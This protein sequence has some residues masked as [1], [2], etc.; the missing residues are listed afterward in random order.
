MPSRS[1][2][3]DEL[4]PPTP[5]RVARR[6][7]ALA[8]VGARSLLEQQD[9]K[10]PDVEMTRVRVVEWVR[11]AGVEDE[12]EPGERMLLARG[13]GQVPRQEGVN[14]TWRLEGLVVLAWALGRFDLPPHDEMVD[15]GNL[16]P[17]LSILNVE[18]AKELLDAATLRPPEEIRQGCARAFAI[19]WRLRQFTM[20]D[21]SPI[22]FAEFARSAW[23]GPLDITGIRLV[24]KDLAVG[25][26]SISKAR[27]DNVGMVCSSAMERHVAFNW[28]MGETE[29]YSETG[30]ST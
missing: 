11:A 23:F 21:R 14:G 16:L 13:L 4:R 8:A 19:H 18:G 7:L 30:A 3:D 1:R 17:A 20:V 15:P 6:A 22:D 28:L 25:Q 26:K 10:D 12:L 29:I 2:E 27:E 9:L 24:E 5:G